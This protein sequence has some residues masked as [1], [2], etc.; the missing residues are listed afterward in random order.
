MSVAHVRLCQDMA[1]SG[2]PLARILEAGQGRSAAFMHY[3]KEA[4]LERV[5]LCLCSVVTVWA[6][7]VPFSVQELAIEVACHSEGEEW[8]D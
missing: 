1:A 2:A 5:S 6:R 7:R 8:I 3:I 4:D